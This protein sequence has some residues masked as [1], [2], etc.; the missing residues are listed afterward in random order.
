MTK[1]KIKRE[2]EIFEVA[3]WQFCG[4]FSVVGLVGGPMMYAT[5]SFAIAMVSGLL[6]G[7]VTYWMS[8]IAYKDN[9]EKMMSIQHKMDSLFLGER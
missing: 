5:N 7:V 2:K 6:A 3:R 4:S 1:E 9:P 8:R